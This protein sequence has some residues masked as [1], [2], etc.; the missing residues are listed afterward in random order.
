MSAACV[1]SPLVQRY[2]SCEGT[3]CMYTSQPCSTHVATHTVLYICAQL[4]VSLVTELI[5]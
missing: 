4:Y 5:L 2:L 1:I 3:E